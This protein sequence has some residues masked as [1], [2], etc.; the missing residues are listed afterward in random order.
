MRAFVAALVGL[1]SLSLAGCK[2]DTNG[3]WNV[4]RG[5]YHDE[6]L[7]GDE[8][9]AGEQKENDYEDPLDQI[10]HSPKYRAINND[11]GYR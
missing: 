7:I 4:N 8:A 6:Y 10:I 11:L 2:L 1:S 3:W 5:T 9:R